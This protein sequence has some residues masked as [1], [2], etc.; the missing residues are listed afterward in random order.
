[1]SQQHPLYGWEEA[2]YLHTE[3]VATWAQSRAA[4]IFWQW[5]S[6]VP[7]QKELRWSNPPEIHSKKKKGKVGQDGSAQERHSAVPC[8]TLAKVP[9]ACGHLFPAAWINP[10]MRHRKRPQLVLNVKTKS[11]SFRH[12]FP[13]IPCTSRHRPGNRWPRVVFWV[14]CI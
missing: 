6:F 14:Q 5:F 9:E 7:K 13:P 2:I 3:K 10:D 1:M 11:H 4:V 8:W 12:L